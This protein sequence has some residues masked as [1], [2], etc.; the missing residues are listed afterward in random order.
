MMHHNTT[1][2]PHHPPIQLPFKILQWNAQSLP[3][4]GDELQRH[5]DTINHKPSVICIQE[6]WLQE[7]KSFHL[8]G[9]STS[10]RKDRPLR[11]GGGVAIYVLEGKAH[12]VIPVVSSLE[13]CAVEVFSGS[14]HITICNIYHTDQPP[15]K[16]LFSDIIQQ[17]PAPVFFC[18]DFNA[19][20]SLWGGRYDDNKGKALESFIQ[21]NGFIVLNDGSGTRLASDGSTSVIDLA[22]TT[23]RL[24]AKSEWAIHQESTLGS[25]HFPITTVISDQ[26]QQRPPPGQPRW[27]MNRANWSLY[28]TIC[29]EEVT[30]ALAATNVDV[31]YKGVMAGINKAAER[32]IPVSRPS[33]EKPGAPWWNDEC[34]KAAEERKEA[35]NRVRRTRHPDDY[36]LYVA[37]KKKCSLLI[38]KTKKEHWR[39]YCAEVSESTTSKEV[40]DRVRL[41][42][43]RAVKT[44]GPNLL[45]DETGRVVTDSREIA[46]LLAD[47]YENASSDNNLS[48]EFIRHRRRF[49][50]EQESI[51]NDRSEYGGA[52]NELFTMQELRTALAA[53]KDTAPGRDNITASMLRHLPESSLQVLLDLYNETWRQQQLPKEWKHSKIVPVLKPQKDPTKAVSHRPIS[54][55]SVPCKVME[56]MVNNRLTWYLERNNL[57]SPI[58]SGFRSNRNTMDNIIRLENAIQSTLRHGEFLVVV[59]LDLEKAY[60][61]MWVNGLLCKLHQLGIR[62]K[63]LGWLRSFLTQRTSQVVV[64]GVGS[65]LFKCQNGSPQGGVVCPTVFIVMTNNV[66][67]HQSCVLSGRYADDEKRWYRHKHLPTLKGKLEED[68]ALTVADYRRWGFK[69]AATKTTATVFTLNEVPDDFNI[70]IEGANIPVGKT[71][72]ILGI[73]LDRKL[74]WNDHI[75]TVEAHCN[76]TLQLLRRITGYSWGTQAK[77]LLS[78]YRALIR[79][80]MDY[81]GELFESASTSVKEKLNIIQRKA[82]RICLGLPK[83][84]ASASTL[85][86]AG[87]MPLDLRRNITTINSYFRLRTQTPNAPL[88]NEIERWGNSAASFVERA[89][90]ITKDSG[91]AV[92]A[93]ERTTYSA[94]PPWQRTTPVLHITNPNQSDSSYNCT[95]LKKWRDHLQIYTDGARSVGGHSSAA[96]VIP[97]R[98]KVE[99]YRLNGSPSATACELTAISLAV[100]WAE[101]SSAIQVV[102][103]SDSKEALNTICSTSTSKYPTLKRAILN[104]RS[105]MESQ[106]KT[107]NFTWIKAHAGV[108][109]NEAADVA[110]KRALATEPTISI[111]QQPTDLRLLIQNFIKLQW[112]LRWNS[113]PTET[114]AFVR[115]HSP[116]VS[117]K[118]AVFGNSRKDQVLLTRVRTNMLILNSR[119][120]E[121]GKHETGHCAHCPTAEDVTHVLLHCPKY[122]VERRLFS[123]IVTPQEPEETQLQKLMAFEDE[124]TRTAV[125]DFLQKTGITRR[126][127]MEAAAYRSIPPQQTTASHRPSGP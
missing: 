106:G 17:L 44:K 86:E 14:S 9:Y 21:E 6:T 70:V 38:R 25:D 98:R 42:S 41:M 81:G 39:D 46:D 66:A 69:V 49:E 27:N 87:E 43:G 72:K 84:T 104:V 78:I 121:Y 16:S 110:A 93:V 64:G 120:K 105:R 33:T 63:M 5:L 52:I 37:V 108:N 75:R 85:R 107:L 65:R 68:L 24:A 32:S 13:C 100:K 123:H 58:Q 125:L 83:S 118:A 40:W 122:R 12:R 61:L 29:A 94:E 56:R 77:E 28:T 95:V 90:A 30:A 111:R 11:R 112:Q 20:H 101:S 102:I 99:Q 51:L 15:S 54:L 80:K 117:L 115:V 34:S 62:G 60:D 4:H 103:L 67:N 48:E 47:Q 59:T 109:G 18:G 96:F 8:K 55:T 114:D 126:L 50:T 31:F 74:T 45:V 76:K 57:L 7:N 3:A 10:V 22:F 89:A 53:A 2:V 82:L 124:R 36:N 97:A 23:P 1:T 35:L 88:F 127:K 119:L 73:T 79:S 19:H 113:A 71:V 116:D 92:N 91:V 26:P